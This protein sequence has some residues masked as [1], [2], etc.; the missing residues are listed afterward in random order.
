VAF[1]GTDM[2]VLAALDTRNGKQL[3]TQN[4]PEKTG[5]GPSIVDGRVLWGF[6][7]FLFQGGGN[8]GVISFTVGK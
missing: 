6:G 7:F 1:V 3:W 4:A 8:G 2:G 5:C